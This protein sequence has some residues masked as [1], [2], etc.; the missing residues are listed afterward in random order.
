M[1][2]TLRHVQSEAWSAASF[3]PLARSAAAI[4]DDLIAAVAPVT[5]RRLLD[6]ACGTGPVALRA[7]ALGAHVV[8]VDIAQSMIAE[9]QRQCERIGLQAVFELGD[10][11]QLSYPQGSFDIVTSAQGVMFTLHH[12]RAAAELARVCSSGGRL[13]LTVLARSAEN[14]ELFSL[15]QRY[16]PPRPP[17]VDD[18]LAWGDERRVRAL[19]GGSFELSFAQ[20]SAPITA[21]S[22]EEL[23]RLL[24]SHC[25]PLKT[26]AERLPPPLERRLAAGMIDYYERYRLPAGGLR[27]PRTYLLIQGRRR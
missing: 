26:I 8:G 1:T 14:D 10:A 11:E 16:L 23:W 6:V 3:G 27:V 21:S 25:G 15:W 13:A 2:D 19:L 5:G 17:D 12:A 9:A 7:A 24:R 18:P 22:P 20:R 4:H